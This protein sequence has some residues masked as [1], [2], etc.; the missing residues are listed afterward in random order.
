MGCGRTAREPC[1]RRQQAL[2]QPR[3]FQSV[4]PELAGPRAAREADA[5]QRWAARKGPTSS[6]GDS[7]CG[8][9]ERQDAA[10]RLAAFASRSRSR[11]SPMPC[12]R[13]RR[14][15]RGCRYPRALP[16]QQED[17]RFVS[18]EPAQHTLAPE[19]TLQRTVYFERTASAGKPTTF[20]VTY[21]LTIF[22]QYHPIDPAKVT[23]VE[24]TR[25]LAP[26][27][28]E[29]PPHIVFTDD[30]REFSRK[31][32]GD[33]AQPVPDRA[34]SCFSLS[35]ASRGPAR[36]NTRR[37]ETS[38]TTHCTPATRTAASRRCC[39]WPCCA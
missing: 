32:I 26:Y 33:G 24:P 15:A 39:S 18:S 7:R 1:D 38:A 12:R 28:G 10:S 9:R 17:I 25:E 20:S 6:P 36:W 3:A 8:A 30:L 2:L 22:G 13:A 16:G 21:E 35:I 29:R 37:C 5:V 19:S 34:A 11:S 14:F 27:M 23:Q 4:P 31:A